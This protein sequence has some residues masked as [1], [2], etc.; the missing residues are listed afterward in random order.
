[1]DVRF[2][3]RATC[4]CLRRHSGTTAKHRR[5]A[6]FHFGSFVGTHSK[7]SVLLS[8]LSIL[9]VVDEHVDLDNAV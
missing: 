2:V 1:M 3:K 6:K 9:E 5:R 7:K 8:S 4:S